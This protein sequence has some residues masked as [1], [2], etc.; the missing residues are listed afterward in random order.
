LHEEH[1]QRFVADLRRRAR[2]GLPSLGLVRADGQ[3]ST[4]TDGSR[5]RNF[6]AL[7]GILTN[8]LTSGEAERIGLEREFIVVIPY[9]GTIRAGRRNP[10]T[11][12]VAMA[13]V[14]E[15]DL[16]RLANEHDPRDRGI[17]DI[18]ETIIATGRRR[19]EVIELRLD[20]IGRYRGLPML[21]HDQTK[22]GNYNEGI[23]IPAYLYERLEARRHKTLA[24]FE[25]LR[26]RLPTPEER[27]RL[28]LF[29]SDVRNTSRE[30]AISDGKFSTSFRAW[31][32][33]LDLGGNVPHQARHTLA[34]KLLAAGANLAHIRHYLGH[35]SD[36]MA[37]HYAHVQHSDLDDYLS[38]VWVAGPG[39]V[40]PGQLLFTDTT[41]LSR[42]EAVA[43]ALDLSRRSTPTEGGI[44]TFQPVVNGA[45]CPWNMDCTNCD[46]FVLS[47]ADLLYWRRKQEQ[48]RS[49]AER[50]PSDEMADW[51]HQAFEP[52]ARAIAGLEKALSGL[53]LLDQA[54]A[55]DLRRPQD[56]FQRIWSIYNRQYTEMCGWS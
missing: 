29:P 48:W 37:E 32:V 7:R 1:A 41:P 44:C 14:E 13:L 42:E 39:T 43:L 3:P 50:A 22:V 10:F 25:H 5:Q 4:V 8:A 38:A 6:N 46:K 56:Y 12:E 54:L 52:T 18:W 47:G 30:R 51:L 55:L 21:W 11:D 45:A 31:V 34:T 27:P 16:A 28:A 24:R 19:G 15:T 49:L 53:G 17:R 33:S 20:C 23:R 40:N 26:G 36:R 2:E 35:V 9:G